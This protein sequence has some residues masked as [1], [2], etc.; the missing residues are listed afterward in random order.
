MLPLSLASLPFHH[1]LDPLAQGQ[2]WCTDLKPVITYLIL[3][4]FLKLQ[5]VSIY[6]FT[7][8]SPAEVS[9]VD[10]CSPQSESVFRPGHFSLQMPGG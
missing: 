10:Y 4:S 1:L 8:P 2:A 7:F 6:F 5:V 9:A 3:N